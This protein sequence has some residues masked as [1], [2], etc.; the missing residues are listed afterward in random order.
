MP[1][2]NVNDIE[3]YYETSGNGP[4]LTLVMG[5]GCSARQWQWMV[6]VF[7]ESFRVLV[8]DNRGVGR[9]GKPD[10]EYTTELFADDTCELLKA[11]GVEKTHL[12]G[13]SMGGLIAQKFALKYPDMVDKLVLGCTLPNFTHL[14]PAPDDLERMQASQLLPLEESIEEMMRLFLTEDFLTTRHDE[15]AEL[16]KIMMYEKEEQGQDAFF[17]QL[18]AAQNHD[19]LNDVSEIN[20]P[21]LMIS[22]DKDPIA[23]VANAHFLADR[24]HNSTLAI[25]K[26]VQHA[27]WVE[28]YDEACRIIKNYLCLL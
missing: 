23:P 11:L 15:A 7:A 14:P 8:F 6:P 20:V 27:F 18:G 24:I 4:N 9:S 19:T 22:G 25:M 12:C 5:L 3:I 16:K 2:I 17:M 28:K 21:T 1:K 13:A 26:G 10:M